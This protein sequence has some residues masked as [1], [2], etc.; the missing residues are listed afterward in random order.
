MYFCIFFLIH[1]S[2]FLFKKMRIFLLLLLS[3]FA[4]CAY[5]Q[6]VPSNVG[7]VNQAQYTDCVQH[8]DLN[9]S[10]ATYQ[11]DYLACSTYC[12]NVQKCITDTYI[13]L[14]QTS[15]EKLSC[16]VD[17]NSAGSVYVNIFF[18][19]STIIASTIFVLA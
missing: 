9:Q 7:C 15:N 5:S 12:V 18:L 14:C 3:T 4:L 16:T 10:S 17:C 11:C 1:K 8:C 13:K 2:E 19:L 6:I